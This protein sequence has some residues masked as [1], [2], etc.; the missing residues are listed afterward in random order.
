MAL[1]IVAALAM[2]GQAAAITTGQPDMQAA[3]MLSP[4]VRLVVASTVV[5]AT[6]VAADS[7]AAGV[8][9][10]DS[11]AAVVVATVVAVD[12]GNQ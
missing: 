1:A 4:V 3:D 10:V 12:T 6:A 8:A 11:T 2:P 7:T 5:A 9:A